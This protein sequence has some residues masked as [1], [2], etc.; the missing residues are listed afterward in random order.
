MHLVVGAVR[1]G[2]QFPEGAAGGEAGFQVVL[3]GRRRVE[4]A[5][6]DVDDAVRQ[7]QGLVKLLRVG[8]LRHW[9]GRLRV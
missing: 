7:L 4:L 8:N 5:A 3:L 9:K 1:A 2:D 6:D